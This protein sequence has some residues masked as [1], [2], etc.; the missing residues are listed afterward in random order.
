MLVATIAVRFEAPQPAA[1]WYAD[2]LAELVSRE[3]ER[4]PQAHVVDAPPADLTIGGRLDGARLH[5]RIT[6]SWSAARTISGELRVG[7]VAAGEL[8]RH[9]GEIVR[10]IF[11]HGGLLDER[12]P[13]ST[14]GPPPQANA[15][16][17]PRLA[18]ALVTL[19]LILWLAWPPA[20]LALLMGPAVRKRR[21]ASWKWSALAI[22]ALVIAF[23]ATRGDPRALVE[24]SLPERAVALGAGMLWGAFAWIHLRWIFAPLEGLGQARHDA[25]WTLLRAW[26]LLALQ[27]I[28]LCAIYLPIGMLT[29]D[30]A[31]A[32]ALSPRATWALALPAAGLFACFWMLT[33]VDNL[34]IWLDSKLVHGAATDRNPWHFT[35]RSYLRGCLR[36]NGV[37]IGDRLLDRTL[38]LPAPWIEIAC[39]GGGFAR[40]RVLVGLTPRTVAL[41][42]LPDERDAPER[43]VNPDELPFGVVLPGQPERRRPV[44]ARQRPFAP[45]PQLVGEHVTLL[46]WAMPQP[47]GTEVS[48]DTYI[49]AQAEVKNQ[50]AAFEKRIDDEEVD[51]TDPTHKDFLFGALLRELGAVS[52][53]DCLLATLRHSLSL[54]LPHASWLP[55][56]LMR[57]SRWIWIKVLA[58][59]GEVVADAYAALHDGL[60]PL[61]QFLDLMQGGTP[62]LTTRANEPR[63]IAVSTEIFDRLEREGKPAHR[64]RLVWLSRFFYAPLGARLGR[65]LAGVAIALAVTTL[66]SFGAVRAALRY[67]PI[68]SARMEATNGRTETR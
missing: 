39:Y 19:V 5:W 38:F 67:H 35:M 18:Y 56:N 6:P 64:E 20:L 27:R 7:G 36:R 23:A 41:G 57:A 42:E 60:H 26:L 13:P 14:T 28:V 49:A 21:P 37:E 32:L 2:A 51:D 54:A 48:L 16:P 66:L 8:Q 44:R 45:K 33:L 59:P 10:P 53:G 50:Y 24:R 12:P 9:V 11:Q 61:I 55:R 47:F 15:A 62:A 43:N 4:F 25:L 3:L 46:G 65:R 22:V 40:P 52:R 1:A 63:L 30:G 31:A 29:L 34:A 68:Y 17:A 58:G